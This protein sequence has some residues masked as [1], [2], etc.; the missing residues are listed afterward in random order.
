MRNSKHSEFDAVSIRSGPL[1]L[2]EDTL[3]AVDEMDGQREDAKI[4]DLLCAVPGKSVD[5]RTFQV[6]ELML[7]RR[8]ERWISNLLHLNR[9]GKIM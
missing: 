5:R 7:Q 4:L 6:F 2:L 1:I 8:P 3:C 9:T